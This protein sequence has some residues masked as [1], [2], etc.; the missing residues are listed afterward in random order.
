MIV[1]EE[2]SA[3]PA[4]NLCRL[5]TADLPEYFGLKE[6]NENYFEGIKNRINFAASLQS[7][8]IGLISIDFPYPNNANIYWLGI[9]KD[10][11]RQG[12]GKKLMEAAINFAFKKG[13]QTIT[14]ETLAP[15]EDDQNYL[16]TYK[17]YEAIDFMPLFDLKPENYEWNMVYMIKLLKN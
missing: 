7:I 9:L 8:Y 14:V 2:I 6:A 13:A 16:K 4:E 11:Q 17:F 12:I 15:L 5:I 10:Y 3:V 1:I